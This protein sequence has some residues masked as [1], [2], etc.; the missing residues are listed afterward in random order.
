MKLEIGGQ[1]GSAHARQPDGLG[2]S[3]IGVQPGIPDGE[4][5]CNIRIVGAR[6]RVLHKHIGIRIV[7][8]DTLIV[9]D[10][11][12]LSIAPVFDYATGTGL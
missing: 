11:A 7:Q 4:E 5:Q 3:L 9:P 6:Q 1:V 8:T 12:F 10:L 2:H